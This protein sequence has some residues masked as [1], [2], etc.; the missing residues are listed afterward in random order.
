MSIDLYLVVGCV[1]LALNWFTIIA[2]YIYGKA[3]GNFSWTIIMPVIGP[4]LINIWSINL[5]FN[6]GVLLIPWIFDIGTVY[7]ILVILR[8]M[9]EY[10]QYSYFTKHLTLTSEAGNQ[11][12][13]IS[14]HKNNLFI[15][16]YNWKRTKDGPVIISM[17]D[18]GTYDIRGNENYI[19]EN[20]TGKIRELSKSNGKYVC[21]D[22]NSVGNYNIDG[23]EF[24]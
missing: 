10:W 13:Q 11:R 9:E 15:I 16:R 2:N 20:H 6:L 8:M 21:I 4:V 5:G 1:F 19:L 14:F 24:T 17:N 3:T 22:K 23:Y 18:F 7:F 12:A